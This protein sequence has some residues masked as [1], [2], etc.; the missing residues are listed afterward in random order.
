MLLEFLVVIACGIGTFLLRFLPIWR[1]RRRV[2]AP[3]ARR[4]SHDHNRMQRF[5]A[6]IG[7]AALTALL[8]VSLWPF[9]RDVSHAP[10][11]MSA[12]IALVVIVA[13]KRLT[14]GLAVPTLLG[15]AVY[16]AL[17]HWLTTV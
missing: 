13:A 15:A 4:P 1:A 17:M 5:F 7:P 2:H 6:G 9:F 10:R 12:S 8:I 3:H 11:W 14:R 16:G